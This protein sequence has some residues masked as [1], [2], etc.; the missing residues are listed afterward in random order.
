MNWFMGTSQ[1]IDNG[2]NFELLWVFCSFFVWKRFGKAPVIK[3][4]LTSVGLFQ[5]CV[6]Q[7]ET[8]AALLIGC[9]LR[10]VESLNGFSWQHVETWAERR[11][12]SSFLFLLPSTPRAASLYGKT[13]SAEWLHRKSNIWMW[14]LERRS[15]WSTGAGLRLSFIFKAWFWTSLVFLIDQI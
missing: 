11:V 13:L 6:E 1:Y 10:Q 15:G 2:F 9:R 5:F 12:T 14:S 4:F 7:V 3:A 8:E